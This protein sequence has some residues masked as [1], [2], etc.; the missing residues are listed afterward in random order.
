M[1]KVTI[2][3][4]TCILSQLAFSNGGIPW[5]DVRIQDKGGSVSFANDPEIQLKSEKLKISFV[6]D[7]AIV[8]CNYSLL[9]KSS[10]EKNIDFAFNVADCWGEVYPEYYMISADGKTLDAT[11]KIDEME[12]DVNEPFISTFNE[13]SKLNL[14]P[15]KTLNLEITYKIKT[16]SNGTHV[17][18]RFS[19][20]V[21]KYNLFPAL[22]FGNG[23][24]DEFT[25][26][27]DK[28][29]IAGYGGTITGVSGVDINCN[30]GNVVTKTFRNFDLKKH[31]TLEISYNIR[32]WYASEM[33]RN[34]RIWPEISVSSMLVEGNT[35]Y[36]KW[37]LS[38]GDYMTPW[39]EGVA[40]VGKGEKITFTVD[41]H[42]NITQLIL[43]NGF[44]KNEKTYTENCRVKKIRLYADDKEIGTFDIPDRKFKT[45]M[46]SNILDVAEL[47]NI[48]N[49]EWDLST[50]WSSLTNSIW[51]DRNLTIE[52][53]EVWPGTKYKDTCISEL[54]LLNSPIP[55]R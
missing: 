53:L 50:S 20:N 51:F 32:N 22:S 39:V 9:N 14:K 30:T 12:R 45:V 34:Y 36:S 29:D 46:D 52:I 37:C 35:E 11:L 2:F 54:I 21:F 24:I 19:D 38:D 17:V 40:D 5:N 44:R 28:T 23:I 42:T 10:R 41:K 25:L 18:S 26:T 47:V 15:G 13:Y 1:K 43:V 33:I 48:G 8:N 16:Q 7:F 55:I 27:I 49:R 3:V 6:N 4:L 31:W